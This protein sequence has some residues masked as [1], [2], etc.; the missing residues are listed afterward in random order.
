MAN[1]HYDDVIMSE[2]A[3]QITSLTIVYS[4]VLSGAYQSKHQSSASLA[5]VWEIHRWPVNFPHKRPV[6][7]KIF[8]FDDVIMQSSDKEI[9]Q[10]CNTFFSASTAPTDLSHISRHTSVPYPTMHHF[11][12]EMWTFLLQNGALWDICLMHCGGCEMEYIADI[13]YSY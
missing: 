6:T 11:L 7:R 5:F 13:S 12:T 9:S 3:S 4:T 2:I 10:E 8:P 1:S